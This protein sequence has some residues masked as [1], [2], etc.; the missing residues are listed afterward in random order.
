MKS[1][2]RRE[3]PLIQPRGL[4]SAFIGLFDLA[5]LSNIARRHYDLTA[6]GQEGSNLRD[7]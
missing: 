3:A 7:Y 6:Q 1:E 4:L 2:G 5:Q